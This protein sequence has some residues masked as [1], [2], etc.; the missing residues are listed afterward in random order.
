MVPVA[1]L[2]QT[3]GFSVYVCAGVPYCGERQKA[4]RRCTMRLRTVIHALRLCYTAPGLAHRS[5]ARMVHR[6][7]T[8]VTHGRRES[9]RAIVPVQRLNQ[10]SSEL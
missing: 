10:G 5:Q 7:D 6:K 2:E 1:L 9:D 8:T 4:I 3:L